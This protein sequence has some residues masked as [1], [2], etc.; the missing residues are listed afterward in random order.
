M[1]N[2]VP[3]SQV[4]K[5]R[6]Y[7]GKLQGQTLRELAEELGC[8]VETVRK[9]WRKGRKI[10]IE[11][12]KRQRQGRRATG[13]LSQYD[14]LVAQQAEAYKR[15]HR[16]WG[17]D[18]VLIELG[19]DPQLAGL[20]LPKRSRL[21]A[22]FKERCPECV[23]RYK[24]QPPAP[25]SIHKAR[26]V[27][28]V[29]QMDNQEEIH[30]ANGAMAVVCNIRDPYG[31]APIASQAFDGKVTTRSRKLTVAEFRQVLRSAFTEWQTLPDSVWTDNEL[32]LIGNPSSDFPSLLTLYLVG[33]GIRHVFI[34][35]GKPTD[36]A[37]VERGHRT[38]D[39]LAFND[40]ALLDVEHLQSAL[41][42]ERQ[43]Y[44]LE[45]PCHASDC[46]GRPPLTAHPELLRP[47]RYYQPEMEPLLFSMQLV[48][49][50]LATFTFE[51]MISNSGAVALTRQIS[52]GRKY[53]RQIP[54]RR[55]LV[56][57]DP[58]SHEW[59][60]YQKSASAQDPLVEL[61]RRPIKYLDFETLTGLDPAAPLPVQP[62][63]LPL[64]FPVPS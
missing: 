24:A 62:V 46:A 28:E 50:Y 12:L 13:T 27:H 7:T 37:H 55:V 42:R 2:R 9:W 4:E 38:L 61:T 14:P 43:V 19:K 53:A 52:I 26:A 32:R 18:R 3:L 41:D 49:D 63:Q 29:W 20:K 40:E 1:G 45:F 35:P 6:I 15:Q 30:L 36:H 54:D 56:R 57:C 47:R 33:L 11:G 5:G 64:P 60:F 44:L 59:V 17:A 48:Y 51:R 34:R 10:G 31:A 21:A 8:S 16:G 58:V 23:K 25:A 39:N 22:F